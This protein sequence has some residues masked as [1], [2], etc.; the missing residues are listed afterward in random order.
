MY[1]IL[2]QRF[3][4][5]PWFLVSVVAVHVW[6]AARPAGF[7]TFF[8]SNSGIVFS[9]FL[10]SR[11]NDSGSTGACRTGCSGPPRA[12]RSAIVAGGSCG[13]RGGWFQALGG[14]GGGGLNFG[15]PFVR[16]L[17]FRVEFPAD[18]LLNPFLAFRSA[19]RSVGRPSR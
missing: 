18:R 11:R 13:L 8:S 17:V 10:C 16:L 7:P 12:V 9:L 5:R 2:F 6:K 15:R 3:M 19:E 1:S 4:V 14:D